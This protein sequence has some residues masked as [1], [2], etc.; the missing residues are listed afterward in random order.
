MLTGEGC[1]LTTEENG[2]IDWPW[3]SPCQEPLW[4][5]I[6]SGS[7]GWAHH[8]FL[9]AVAELFPGSQPDLTFR[10]LR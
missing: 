2:S 7:G 4:S 5:H 6:G 9:H 3:S 10:S 1:S 8:I